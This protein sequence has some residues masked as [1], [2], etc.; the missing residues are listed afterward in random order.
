VTVIQ[1][2]ENNFGV[3][4]SNVTNTVTYSINGALSYIFPNNPLSMEIYANGVLLAKGSSFDYTA[5][6]AGYNLT[7]AFNNNFTLLNQQTFARI[8]AA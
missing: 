4:A 7:Q 2:S 3:P 5:T 8:D 1:Y 6:S